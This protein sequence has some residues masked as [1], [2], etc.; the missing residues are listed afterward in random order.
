[1]T[2]SSVCGDLIQEYIYF[3]HSLSENDDV[4]VDDEGEPA[5]AAWRLLA[6]AVEDKD[7]IREIE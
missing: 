6:A 7:H 4:F 3:I 5:A 1:V 2:S